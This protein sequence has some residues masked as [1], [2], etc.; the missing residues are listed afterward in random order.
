MVTAQTPLHKSV[1]LYLIPRLGDL[2]I[3]ALFFYIEA[4]GKRILVDSG[5]SAADLR[6]NSQFGAPWEDVRSFEE[7]LGRV[8]IA[9]DGI[10]IV[11]QTHLHFD[12]VLN[13]HKCRNAKVYVQRAELE[14][15]RDPHPLTA[16][17]YRWFE[18]SGKDF[19]YVV[20]DGDHKLLPGIELLTVPGHTRGCQA[21]AVNTAKGKTVI[22]GFCSINEN[23]YPPESLNSPVPVIA[24]GIH[25]N[26]EQAFESTKR[27]KREANFIL[28]MHEPS[29]ASV[30]YI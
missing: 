14:E 19:D 27:V 7:C 17:M 25:L 22:T 18:N 16:K 24:P 1:F 10:D 11:I 29:L 26:A 8:G 12:H 3:P 5:G 30:E 6:A 9:P 23:F 21:V 28:P 13:T 20:V 2:Q 4:D 15:A